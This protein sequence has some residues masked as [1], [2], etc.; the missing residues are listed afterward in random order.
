ME[1][2]HAWWPDAAL[3]AQP[4]IYGW[5][6]LKPANGTEPRAVNHNKFLETVT[7]QDSLVLQVLLYNATFSGL[8]ISYGFVEELD[9]FEKLFGWQFPSRATP[10]VHPAR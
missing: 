1:V 4:R 2:G 9:F 3:A 7:L 8:I 6:N 5:G 10:P